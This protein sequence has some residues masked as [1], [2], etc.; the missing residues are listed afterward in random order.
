MSSY[1]D[2]QK[3]FYLAQQR[4][5]T[6][7]ATKFAKELAAQ[8]TDYSGKQVEETNL[9]AGDTLGGNVWNGNGWVS[10]DKYDL[11]LKT[12]PSTPAV[13][14]N[15]PQSWLKVATRGVSNLPGSIAG[16]A[17]DVVSS[18]L[19][20][21]DT[22]QG[23]LDLGNAALQKVLPDAI[24]QMMPE[25]T[26]NN[27][28][29]LNA[30]V[31]FYKSRYTNPENFKEALATD[32][33]S[34]LADFSTVLTG[35]GSLASKIPALTKVGNVVAGAGRIVDPLS[36]AVNVA[37]SFGEGLANVIGG[38]GTHTGGESLKTAARAG[39]EGGKMAETFLGNMRGNVPMKDVLDMAKQ[40]VDDMAARK[41]AEYQQGMVGI[42]NDK[43][44]LDFN[45]IDNTLANTYD[46]I[47]FKGKPKNDV[48]FTAFNKIANE[49][50]TWKDLDPAEFHTPLG[51]D[52]LKQRIGGIQESIPYEEKTARMVAKNLYD[53]VKN[54]IT[55][56]APAYSKVMKDYSQASD[57]INE[58]E[59]TFS[60]K[61]SGNPDTAMRKL[62]SLMRNNVNTNYGNRLDLFK[63]LEDQGR[64]ELT[65]AIAGQALNSWT[66]RGLANAG[67]TGIGSYAVGGAPLAVPMLMAQSPRLMGEAAYGVGLLSKPVTKTSKKLKGMFDY[68][69]VDPTLTGNLLYQARENRQ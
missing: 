56:Q 62:Q 33:A 37:P 18:V 17:G 26:R 22:A 35:G 58:I 54:E 65:S 63:T 9:Q 61:Q 42:T 40:N 4:G 21:I 55:N 3:A 19:H 11:P 31:D 2:L 57:L 27:P 30:V 6:E 1:S 51:L 49:I 69:N 44:V 34:V 16:V 64:N 47:T 43:S 36:I 39:A 60:L 41:A 10:P 12:I 38:T 59:R 15:K 23:V 20:P 50:N 8:G 53:S 29:K 67:L 28:A 52:S 45:K 14:E 25:S 5:D 48:A 68:L 32:P 66:P 7:Y 13:Q 24:V 46:K